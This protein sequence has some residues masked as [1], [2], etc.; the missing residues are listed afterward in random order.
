MVDGRHRRQNPTRQATQNRATRRRHTVRVL[1]GRASATMR[2]DDET[3]RSSSAT[4]RRVMTSTST[5]Q[6]LQ[7]FGVGTGDGTRTL[8]LRSGVMGF[9]NHSRTVLGTP[10]LLTK[11]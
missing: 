5:G 2:T 6:R 1:G 4:T 8:D 11:T 7:N 10:W 3:S 9:A